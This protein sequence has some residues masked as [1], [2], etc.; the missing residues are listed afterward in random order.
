MD[1][2]SLCDWQ[3]RNHRVQLRHATGETYCRLAEPRYTDPVHLFPGAP[4]PCTVT[5][6]PQLRFCK[7]D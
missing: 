3:A 2:N 6:K 4:S 7:L 1:S 5:M